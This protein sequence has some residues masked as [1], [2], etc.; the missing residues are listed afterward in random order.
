MEKTVDFTAEEL[1]MINVAL[2]EAIA[3]AWPELAEPAKNDR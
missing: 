1:Q 3:K 2:N